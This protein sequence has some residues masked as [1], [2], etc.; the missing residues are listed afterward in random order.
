MGFMDVPGKRIT[1]RRAS[2]TSPDA[3]NAF[4]CAILTEVGGMH[5]VDACPRPTAPRQWQRRA[6]VRE[7][8]FAWTLP[9]AFSRPEPTLE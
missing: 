7:K 2:F 9:C 6:S 5:M 1:S 4:A 8:Q 3:A